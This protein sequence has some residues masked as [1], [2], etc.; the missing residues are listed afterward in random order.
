MSLAR[1]LALL[2]VPSLGCYRYA[3]INAEQLVP[4]QDVR[5][6]VGPALAQDLNGVLGADAS[7]LRGEMIGRSD[8]ALF[9]DVAAAVGP[10]PLQSRT[11]KQRVRVPTSQLLRIERRRLD[12]GRTLLVSAVAGLAVGFIA[13][14]ALSGNA[15]ANPS[16]P[17]GD[18]VSQ[19]IHH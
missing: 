2:I 17:P 13:H 3:P 14:A 8:D 12:G 5:A 16:L 10:F 15:G 9:L 1:L 6:R 7:L 18:G 11:L 4:G 19:S